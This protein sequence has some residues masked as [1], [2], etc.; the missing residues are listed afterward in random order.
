MATENSTIRPDSEEEELPEEEVLEEQAEEVEEE[1]VED[2]DK[3]PSREKILEKRLRD[4]QAKLTQLAQERA[5]LA[6]KL[7]VLDR[8]K[9]QAETPDPLDSLDEE[10]AVTNPMVIAK[11][12]KAANAALIRDVVGVLKEMRNEMLGKIEQNDPERLALKTVIDE[13]R[14]D[15]ELAGLDDTVLLKLAKRQRR[16]SP[17]RPGARPSGIPGSGTRTGQTSKPVDIR[18]TDLFKEI[19]GDAQ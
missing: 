10:E 6:G 11:A 5:E 15:P 7:S 16:T 19:Y 14:E 3:P 17:S 13:L 12:A 1:P 18:K 9:D 4:T 2:S 8:P